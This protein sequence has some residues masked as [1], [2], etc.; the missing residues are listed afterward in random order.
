MTIKAI[1]I[2]QGN[3]YIMNKDSCILAFKVGG[4]GVSLGKPLLRVHFERSVH[5]DDR[6]IV[7]DISNTLI[8]P[9]NLVTEIEEKVLDKVFKIFSMHLNLTKNTLTNGIQLHL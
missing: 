1:D 7:L 3:C 9:D 6:S 4:I 8:D 2:R 5:I